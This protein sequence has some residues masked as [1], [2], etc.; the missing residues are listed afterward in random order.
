MKR[1]HLLPENIYWTRFTNAKLR[2]YISNFLVELLGFC[3]IKTT[4]KAKFSEFFLPVRNHLVAS[5]NETRAPTSRKYVVEQGL[6]T[7]NW[8]KA[9]QTFLSH[10]SVFALEKQPEKLNFQSV[11]T[12]KRPFCGYF[13]WNACTHFQK[14]W[15]YSRYEHSK[16]N[17]KYK[18][19]WSHS[20]V[21]I[22]E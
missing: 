15:S 13:E 18:F 21:F 4:W 22:L 20:S 5:F 10:S 14:I 2:K 17:T 12:S 8:S 19:L 6:L 9:F 11:L 7:P 1:V 16:I 3:F